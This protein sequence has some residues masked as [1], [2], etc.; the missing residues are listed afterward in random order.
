MALSTLDRKL[1]RDLGRLKGQ[2]L[3]VALVIAAGV[4]VVV[5][6]IGTYASLSEIRSTYYERHRFADLFVQSDRA[7]LRLAER[8]AALDGVVRLEARIVKDALLDIPG[9]DE[10]ARAQLV[11]VPETR[12]PR[13]NDLL[14]KEGRM[15][16]PGRPDEALVSEA[17]ALEHGLR[18]GDRIEAVVNGK[19]RH[20]RLVGIALSPEFVY[21]IGP[22]DLVPDDRRYAILWMGRSALEA[23][24]DYEGAFND[25]AISLRRGAEPQAVI[26]ALDRMLEPYAG[27]GA[28]T[29]EDQLS[30][31]FVRSDMEQLRNLAFILPPLFLGV[32]AFLLSVVMNRLIDTE[33]EQIGLAKAVGYRNREIGLHYL[34]LVL[35]IALGGIV[36][37]AGIGTLM[38]RA[39]TATYSE[40]YAFPYL[41]YVIDARVYAAAAAVSVAAAVAGALGAMARAVRLPPAVAMRAPP[42]PRYSRG[43]LERLGLGPALP[44]LWRMAFRHLVRFPIRSAFASTGIAAAVA[45]LIM[46]FFF[47]DSIDTMI[48]SFFFETERQ[49]I[50]VHFATDRGETVAHELARLPGVRRVELRRL[51]GARLEHGTISQRTAIFGLDPGAHL[52]GL[53]GPDGRPV[54]LPAAGLVLTDALARKLGVEPGDPV[55]VEVLEG[56]RPVRDVPVTLVVESL[57]GLSAYMDRGALNALM[58]EGRVADAAKLRID[59]AEAPRLYAAIKEIPAIASLSIKDAAYRQFR[60]IMDQTFLL[61]ISFY[62][63]FAAVIA[64]GVVYNTARIAMAEHARELASL[65]VLGFR[66]REVAEILLV[67]LATLTLLALPLGCLL[68]LGLV[69]LL[70][71]LFSSDLYRVPAIVTPATLGTALGIVVAASVAAGLFVA[72]RLGGLDLVAVL[73]SR[74]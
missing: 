62:T 60:G 71:E 15:V 61:V 32:A 35:L 40:N 30:D 12:T 27:F 48:E 50:T 67:E 7:P 4:A 10:P 5:M 3:A 54:A 16:E 68:G 26:D 59:P 21:V 45:L 52:T 63:T 34:K 1:L 24:F 37:G 25:L 18:P 29:R 65:R 73:K 23:A 14:L 58:M 64:L 2:A 53:S 38:G 31:S 6:A 44:R 36:L 42:P 69:E 56:R 51:V 41:T 20:L 47:T 46:T 11:S 8:I 33:R 74:E 72:R 9:M 49:D 28:Y 13:V 22:G 39:V 70:A 57:I 17:F 43:M 19:R 66:K 55:R